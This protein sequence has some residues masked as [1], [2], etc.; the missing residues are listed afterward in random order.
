M[1]PRFPKIR[2]IWWSHF[3][4]QCAQIGLFQSTLFCRHVKNLPEVITNEGCCKTNAI[5]LLFTYKQA[6]VCKS[7]QVF[8]DD[9]KENKKTS[10]KMILPQSISLEHSVCE[11]ECVCI[12]TLYKLLSSV[13]EG[14][15]VSVVFYI[16]DLKIFSSL[17]GL[18]NYT[19][20]KHTKDNI[21]VTYERGKTSGKL[22]NRNDQW[23][24]NIDK[25]I[26]LTLTWIKCGQKASDI[27]YWSSVFINLHYV[28]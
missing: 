12:N 13:L 2:M 17:R 1:L 4:S 9:I 8:K 6:Q 24:K 22:D 5:L 14:Q 7:V 26:I 18:K 10:G 20:S 21:K 27:I 28:S 11:K 19:L 3:Y 25:V 23:P 16:T 15:T